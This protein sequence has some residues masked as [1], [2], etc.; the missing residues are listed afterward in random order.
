MLSAFLGR[1]DANKDQEIRQV[2]YKLSKI[3]HKYG[4][5]IVCL[6]H[7]NKSSGT[8]ALYRGNQSIAVIG[9]ARA[10]LLVGKD[11]DDDHVRVLACTKSN[12]SEKPPS[13]RFRLEPLPSGVCRIAWLGQSQHTADDLVK[14]PETEEKKAEK[15][16]NQTKLKKCKELIQDLLATG[17]M[18]I[19]K[20]KENCAA[21]GFSHRTA[22]RAA[23]QLDLT[24]H[25]TWDDGKKRNVYTW[26]LP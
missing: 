1:V 18:D 15:K 9:H 21:A 13:L 6:R 14:P 17:P 20:V 12:V 25:G 10:G 22:E 5:C 4:C 8:K 23:E 11:P 2:L 19:K 26:S 24:M 3:A 16:L 7:L